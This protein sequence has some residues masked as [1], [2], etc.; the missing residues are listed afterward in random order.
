MVVPRVQ[1]ARLERLV[2]GTPDARLAGHVLTYTARDDEQPEPTSWRM[3]TLGAVMV[4]ID[5]EA[6]DRT[7]IDGAAR[8]YPRHAVAGLRDRPVTLV[9]EAGRSRG[10]TVGLTPMGAYALLGMPLSELAAGDV[11][12]IGALGARGRRLIERLGEAA[13]WTERFR[14]LDEQLL[15]WFI[16][17]PAL[18]VPVRGAWQRLTASAGDVRIGALADEIGWTRQ[19]LHTR[20]RADIGLAPKTVARIARL[21]RAVTMLSSSTSLTSRPRSLAEVAHHCGYADQAHFGREFRALTGTTPME[22]GPPR[23][24]PFAPVADVE[25]ARAS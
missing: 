9:E 6:P 14:I 3:A 5:L 12:L 20:F 22:F 16:D 4:S 23:P 18:A 8:P 15:A 19:H 2:A 1:V 25:A 10:I 17:A 7:V 24:H 21:H 11:D 13:S